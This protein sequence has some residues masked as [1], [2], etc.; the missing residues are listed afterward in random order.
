MLDWTDRHCRKFHRLLSKHARLYTEM[1]TTGALLHGDRQRLLGFSPEERPL[2]LQL[3]GSDPRELAMC[4]E[5]G[6]AFGFDEI[7]LNVGCPSDRVQRGR[8]GACLM[9]EPETV[10]AGLRAMQ[11][12]V[13]IPVTV[14]SRIGV[15]EVDSYEAL[16]GFAKTIH[17]AGCKIL[18]LHAR[19][20][21]LSGLSPK[22][23]RE[24]PPLRYD[25][26]VRLKQDLPSLTLVLNGGLETLESATHHLA[27]LDGV[28]LG[29]SVYHNP[30]LLAAVDQCLFGDPQPPPT[31]EAVV[32]AMMPYV[33][34]QLALGHRLHAISRHMLGLYHGQ[35]GGRLWRRGLGEAAAR[36]GVGVEALRAELEKRRSFDRSGFEV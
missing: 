30:Y 8:F 9:K 27:T 4:A 2:A 18:I 20:A 15:D 32:E 36:P 6:Q 5:M 11:D 34:Q 33:E 7:N 28:M 23:N 22:E 35:P 24:I 14:K 1:L 21:W 25:M 19:K 13:S 3:G 12:R 29:R 16:L 26:A 17:E 31:R 10:A